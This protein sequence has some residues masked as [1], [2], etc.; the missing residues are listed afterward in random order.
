MPSCFFLLWPWRMD[1]RL[2]W[3][4]SLM[5]VTYIRMEAS[6]KG[7][8]L[9]EYERAECC[10]RPGTPSS[11]LLVRK[12]ISYLGRLLYMQSDALLECRFQKK[13][14]ETTSPGL[15]NTCD[16]RMRKKRRKPIH[17]SQDLL[18]IHL[19]MKC[20]KRSRGL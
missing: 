1:S 19:G 14:Q 5:P 6:C 18:V 11:R 16:T 15:G 8:R 13:V 3:K 20:E 7:I 2:R 17:R 4:G 9:L 12:I 10:T